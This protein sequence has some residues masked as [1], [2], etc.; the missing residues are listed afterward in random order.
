M[1]THKQLRAQ[2]LSRPEVT[3]EF[4]TQIE[5]FAFLDEF[6]RARSEQGLT[7]AQVAERIGTTQS[8][9]ARMESALL[10]VPRSSPLMTDRKHR[11]FTAENFVHHDIRKVLEVVAVRS[12]FIFRPIS[13]RFGQAVDCIED[14]GAEGIRR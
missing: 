13:S 6:L 4:E 5:E 7:Q 10:P 12:V 1:L 11:H 14:L 8:A 3:A 2:A 9:V